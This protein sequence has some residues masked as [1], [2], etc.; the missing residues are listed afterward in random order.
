MSLVSEPAAG[1]VTDREDDVCDAMESGTGALCGTA[2]AAAG[3]PSDTTRALAAV[4]HGL[5]IASKRNRKPLSE[6]LVQMVAL[7]GAVGEAA[8]GEQA[9]AQPVACVAPIVSRPHGATA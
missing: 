1:L 7:L 9:M 5:S 2:H 3:W 8:G 4:V 6:A